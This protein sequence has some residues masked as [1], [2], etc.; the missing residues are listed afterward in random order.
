MKSP[1]M[2]RKN[3]SHLTK[4]DTE[5]SEVLFEFDAVIEDFTSPVERRH[6]SYEEHLKN[7]KRLSSSSTGDSDSAESFG[8]HSFSDEKLSSPTVFSPVCVSSSTP[9]PKAKL[10]DTKELEDFIADLDKTIESM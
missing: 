1:K 9:L 6:F 2:K 10:G 8:R 3:T 5:L 7:M 4:V